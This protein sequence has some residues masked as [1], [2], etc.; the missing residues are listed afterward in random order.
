MGF[1]PSNDSK[2]SL[3]A[4]ETDNDFLYGGAGDDDLYGG[5]G[6]DYLDGGA[7]NDFLMGQVG[8]DT[9]FGGDGGDELQ[10]NEGNDKLLGEAGDDKLFGQVGNDT[11]WGGDGTFIVNSVND[12]IYEQAGQGYD[13]D[14]VT[15]AEQMGAEMM[16]SM[17][18]PAI[19]LHVPFPCAQ[20]D[21]VLPAQAN[22]NRKN[23]NARGGSPRMIRF[24]LRRNC[25]RAPAGNSLSRMRPWHGTRGAFASS[26]AA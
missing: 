25:G 22:N 21:K 13:T 3:N 14:G 24:D 8:D 4:G 15:G 6:S 1:T 20:E 9:L 26:R 19:G 7:N 11:L 5:L 2:Q 12:V 10:G 18:V 23:R 16:A 17:L